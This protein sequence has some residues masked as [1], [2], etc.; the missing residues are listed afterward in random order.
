MLLL[1]GTLAHPWCPPPYLGPGPSTSLSAVPHH[2][3][4]WVEQSGSL[5]RSAEITS[6]GHNSSNSIS[7]HSGHR[8]LDR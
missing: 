1:T 6:H 2:W 5:L 3:L 8:P 7:M 4:D